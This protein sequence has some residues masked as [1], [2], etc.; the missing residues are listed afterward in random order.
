MANQSSSYEVPITHI[1]SVEGNI[2]SGKSTFVKFLKE[3]LNNPNVVFVQ[4]PVD[5]WETI[6]DRNGETILT[7]FYRSNEDYAF[8]FQMMAYISRL[9]LLK[10]TVLENPGKIIITERC[11][12]TDK[13]VFA[14]MLY[15]SGK[16][17]DVEYEIY[18]KWFDEF[19]SHLHVD[20]SI[21]IYTTPKKCAERVEKRNRT[22]ESIPLEYLETCHR[23]HDV[24]LNTTN[25]P[26]LTLLNEFDVEDHE[27]MDKLEKFKK[28]ISF[29]I[30]H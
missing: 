19:S 1:Y 13:N 5:I 20:G 29:D 8:A 22:G 6:K 4:E 23:Y 24:W 11:V 3:N 15:D 9:S 25:K 7:K 18:L 14:K 17:E 27:H 2:G 10:K 30:K 26:L 21:Y 28:F 16:I 12:E